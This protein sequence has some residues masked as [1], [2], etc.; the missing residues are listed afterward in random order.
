MAMVDRAV[1]DSANKT[2]RRMREA[3]TIERQSKVLV[4]P[5]RYLML[6]FTIILTP[7]CWLK[8]GTRAND[9]R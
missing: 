2:I 6:L 3:A 1:E 5:K 7:V 8:P 9:R 4:R